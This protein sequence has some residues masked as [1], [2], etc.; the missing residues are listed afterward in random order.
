MFDL[1]GKMSEMKARMEE[2]KKSLATMEVEAEAG[3]GLVR[4]VMTGERKAK[5]LHIDPTLLSTTDQEVL[6]DLIVAAF[7]LASAKA[8]EQAEATVKE[9]TAGLLPNIPGLDFGFGK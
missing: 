4:I 8:E 2:V 3:G 5:A 6:Q 9:K 1:F 7:N